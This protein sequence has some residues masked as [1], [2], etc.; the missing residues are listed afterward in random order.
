M[1]RARLK[2]TADEAICTALLHGCEFWLSE[3]DGLWYVHD[4][5][6]NPDPAESAHFDATGDWGWET[7]P[8]VAR[9]YCKF[10]KLDLLP[11]EV[12]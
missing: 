2:L 9:A 10:Y 5:V 7:R 4:D 8:D 12:T 11:E 1:T 6:D 3:N